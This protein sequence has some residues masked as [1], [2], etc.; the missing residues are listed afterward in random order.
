GGADRLFVADGWGIERSDDDARTFQT[1][2]NGIHAQS[3][4]LLSMVGSDLLA[5]GDGYWLASDDAGAKLNLRINDTVLSTNT[6]G[7]VALSPAYAA[8]KILFITNY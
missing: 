4:G 8:D 1:A 2:E 7:G 5:A 6:N 3:L